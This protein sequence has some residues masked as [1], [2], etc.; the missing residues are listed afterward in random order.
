MTAG[1]LVEA[2]RSAKFRYSSEADLQL[3]IERLFT[4]KGISFERE[5]RLDPRNRIDFVVGGVGIEIKIDGTAKDLAYQVLR[6]LRFPSIQEM[7]VVT[8][9]ASHRQMPESLEGK[10]ITVV[11]LFTSAF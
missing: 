5:V 1:E 11:Y 6:Y 3:G 9:R 10:P 2:L 8:T 7:I 4:E